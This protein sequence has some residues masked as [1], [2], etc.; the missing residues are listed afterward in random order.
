MSVARARLFWQEVLQAA[1][2]YERDRRRQNS[3]AAARGG[4]RPAH[5]RDKSPK[6][7]NRRAPKGERRRIVRE[8][9]RADFR[10]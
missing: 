3:L 8:M 9:V 1:D 4:T 2:D 6:S 5:R 10:L 7:R